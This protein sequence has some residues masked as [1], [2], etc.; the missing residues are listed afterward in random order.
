MKLSLEETDRTR[1]A[2]ISGGYFGPV[3]GAS[4]VTTASQD[5]NIF[6]TFYTEATNTKNTTMI[7]H[8]SHLLSQSA[9]H[10]PLV[11]EVSLVLRARVPAHAQGYPLRFP[12][13]CG[14]KLWL[15]PAAQTRRLGSEWHTARLVVGTGNTRHTIGPGSDRA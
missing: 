2:L 11:P 3:A 6:Y 5:T 12:C 10:H 15:E 4:Y 8:L 1:Q 9:A 7:T 14:G 13:L